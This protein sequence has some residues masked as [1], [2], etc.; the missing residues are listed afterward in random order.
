MLK[1]LAHLPRREQAEP[2]AQRGVR[3]PGGGGRGAEKPRR[4]RPPRRRPPL[5]WPARRSEVTERVIVRYLRERRRLPSRREGYTQKAMVGGHK[6]Y[7]RTGE[8]ED[9]ALG[10]IFIDMHK[11]GAAFRSLMN[12][13][14][15]AVSLG[16]QYGVP[17][18]EF[19]DAFVFTRFEPNGIVDGND[20]IKISTS[21]IDYVF[22]E[23][24]ITYL[25][26][27]D[28]AQVTDEDLK[29]DAVKR[30]PKREAEPAWEGEEVVEERRVP[31][32]VAPA[33]PKVFA[34]ETIHPVVRGLGG[35]KGH[36]PGPGDGG[37]NGDTATAKGNGDGNGRRRGHGRHHGATV[38][39]PPAA[40]G[41]RR[42]PH[43]PGGSPSPRPGRRR[44]PRPPT[45]R[46]RCPGA[47][48]RSSPSPTWRGSRAT[49]GTPARTAAAS[50]WS[51]TAPA[52][53]A[54][55]AGRPAAAADPRAGGSPGPLPSRAGAPRADPRREAQRRAPCS[56][57][58]GGAGARPPPL[59]LRQGDA[60]PRGGLPRVPAAG[61]PGEGPDAPRPRGG[62]AAG[63]AW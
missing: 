38:P 26:R 8:Y 17:L 16:L 36:P 63:R 19:V 4:R 25:D 51:A 1:A 29:P 61:R 41:R 20:R 48:S 24:A 45:S 21:I 7:L 49:P 46:T 58:Q 39:S 37:G 34:P 22:R 6:V 53:S 40:T 5:P 3:G 13:F 10:E 32:P 50:P 60:E 47:R 2:A 18:E 54:R 35:P 9:G 56:W 59:Q 52:S 15:I 43:R 30:D 12:C 42:R 14:A 62:S 27:K 31:A 11:E 57:A 55:P 28:L 44:C 33:V 23:L